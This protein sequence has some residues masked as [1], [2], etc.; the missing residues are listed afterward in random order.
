[1]NPLHRAWLPILHTR[2]GSRHYTALFSNTPRAHQL[3]RTRDWVV[4]YFGH[5]G[6]RGQHTIVTELT[7]P[8][9]GQRVVRGREAECAEYYAR[10]AAAQQ[11]APVPV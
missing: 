6:D 3:G 4:V 2:R 9:Q 1:M 11:R 5:D 7:G 10:E 8:L